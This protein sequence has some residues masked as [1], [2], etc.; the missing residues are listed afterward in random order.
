[1]M[2]PIELLTQRRTVP[3]AYLGPPGPTA[4][5]LATLL[6]AAV[7]VPDHG[8]LGPWRFIVFEGEARLEASRKLAELHLRKQ[9]ELPAE[10]QA[11]DDVRLALAPTVIAVVSRAAPHVKIPEWEQLL[12]AG[13]VAMNLLN[14]ATAIGLAAQWLTGWPAYDADA[15]ALLGLEPFERIAAFVHVG[16]PTMPPLERWRPDPAALVTRWAAPPGD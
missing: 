16:T 9:P 15:R 8:K 2:T 4:K 3:A 14:A 5:Q 7:R 6:A 11:K 1:M 10:E 12:S 13:A